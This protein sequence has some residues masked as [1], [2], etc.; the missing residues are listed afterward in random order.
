VKHRSPLFSL[1]DAVPVHPIHMTGRTKSAATI[2]IL[3]VPFMSQR[4]G[5]TEADAL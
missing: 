1:G 3:M 4:S 5:V 2:D